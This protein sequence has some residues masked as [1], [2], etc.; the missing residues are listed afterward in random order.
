MSVETCP[1][2]DVSLSLD[3]R[4]KSGIGN[5]ERNSS[6]RVKVQMVERRNVKLLVR[7]QGQPTTIRGQLSNWLHFAM[8]TAGTLCRSTGSALKLDQ[9][10]A[11]SWTFFLLFVSA[12]SIVTFFV[13]SSHPLQCQSISVMELS[14]TWTS[15]NTID[16]RQSTQPRHSC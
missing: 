8:L 10:G 16:P 14:Q 3:G 4:R 5:R 12:K 9:G 1:T 13:S 15:G 11:R 6:V 7:S 2:R